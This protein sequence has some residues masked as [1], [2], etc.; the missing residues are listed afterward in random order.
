M[1]VTGSAPADH[2]AG[3]RVLDLC[4]LGHRHCCPSHF[5]QRWPVL[6]PSYLSAMRLSGLLTLGQGLCLGVWIQG[7]WH[8]RP[9]GKSSIFAFIQT[10]HVQAESQAS[11]AGTIS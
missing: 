6:S 8:S 5:V 3:N 2:W 4:K 11:W 7:L 10:Q 1:Q 9:Q